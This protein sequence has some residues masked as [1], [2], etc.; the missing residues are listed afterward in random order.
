M[1][2]LPILVRD[3]A[4]G[5]APVICSWVSS[6]DDLRTISADRAHCLTTEILHR[7]VAES[8]G[9]FVIQTG[10]E[11]VIFC[12]ISTAEYKLPNGCIEACHLVTSP[13]HR[14]KY[15]ATTLLNYIRLVAAQRNYRRLVGRIVPDNYPGLQ[16]AT[17]VHWKEVSDPNEFDSN[18]K[19]F[20]YALRK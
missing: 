20:E 19:W 11:P 5:D 10:R 4:D 16:L 17:Y 1:R 15:F 6:Q 18:N 12:T 9:A 2:N 3:F 7:W 13:I 14:R 8:T